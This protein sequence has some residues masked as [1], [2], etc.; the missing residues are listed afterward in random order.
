MTIQIGELLVAEGLDVRHLRPA[1]GFA[2]TKWFDVTTKR[3]TSS[4]TLDTDSV[5]RFRFWADAA[6]VDACL[7]VA[8]AVK[9][10]ILDPSLPERETEEPVP[11]QHPATEILRR[12][13]TS[14]KERNTG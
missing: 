13:L 10:R 3:T 9:R 6:S 12:I 11:P 14:L 5:V 1:E 8:E 7:V 4:M 2:E